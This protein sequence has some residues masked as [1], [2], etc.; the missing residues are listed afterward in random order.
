MVDE[1]E[2]RMVLMEVSEKWY[3][4]AKRVNDRIVQFSKHI[5]AIHRD[6]IK[7]RCGHSN[8]NADLLTKRKVTRSDCMGWS[9]VHG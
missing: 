9:A 1:S 4:W 3:F 8:S 6:D 7:S 2:R 5:N